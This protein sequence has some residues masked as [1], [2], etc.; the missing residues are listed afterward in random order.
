LHGTN[1]LVSRAYEYQRLKQGNASNQKQ[2][3]DGAP[4][5]GNGALT[6]ERKRS[7]ARRFSLRNSCSGRLQV[8]DDNEE[9]HPFNMVGVNRKDSQPR[10][11]KEEEVYLS[12]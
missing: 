10:W 6:T 7:P 9:M 11:G 3:V 5:G 2:T 12:F 4:D 8:Q 1:K